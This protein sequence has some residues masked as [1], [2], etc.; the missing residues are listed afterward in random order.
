M[1]DSAVQE[2]EVIPQVLG[3]GHCFGV[4]GYPRADCRFYGPGIL[5]KDNANPA[6]HCRSP[7]KGEYWRLLS[8][9]NMLLIA[10]MLREAWVDIENLIIFNPTMENKHWKLPTI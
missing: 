8:M 4:G 5:R 1:G 3:I 2:V 7:E 9:P 10:I 6:C